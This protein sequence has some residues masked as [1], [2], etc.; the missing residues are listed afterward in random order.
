MKQNLI[1]DYLSCILFKAVSLFT[2]LLPLN[3]SLF[4][5]RRLGDLIY[6]FDAKHRAIAYANIRKA[7]TPSN[8]FQLASNITRR[9]Y[10]AF[11]QNLIEISLIPRMNKRYLKKYIRIE[12]SHFVDQAFKRGK[13]VIFLAMH[14]GSWE[15][16]NI[17]C[18][19]LGLPFMLFVREQGFPRLNALLNSY[20]VKQGARIILKQTGPRQLIEALNSNQSVG[21]TIDQGGKNGEIVN[22][23]VRPPLCLPER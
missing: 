16:S 18:A 3:V 22:S 15:L 8:D 2:F 19:N 6:L 10:R 12:N 5:G 11:G 17:I 7:V 13:G 9:S 4:L 23:L 20:R 21:L 14:E 1:A